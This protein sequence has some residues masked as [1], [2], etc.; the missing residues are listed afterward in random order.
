MNKK[1]LMVIVGTLSM[2]ACTLQTTKMAEDMD[3]KCNFSRSL[4]GGWQQG[5]VTVDVE[6]AAQAAIKTIPGEHNLDKIYHVTQQVV[7]GMNYSIIFGI[8]NG[9]FYLATVFRSLQGTNSVKTLK[10]VPSS[11]SHCVLPN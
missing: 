7:A 2:M 3:P 4:T 9:D 1:L 6:Q 10:K 5:K 8:D 11:V